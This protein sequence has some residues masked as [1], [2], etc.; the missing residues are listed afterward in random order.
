M[1]YTHLTV[2]IL[3]RVPAVDAKSDQ[4]IHVRGRY[5]HAVNEL[6]NGHRLDPPGFQRLVW[7][8]QTGIIFT[9]SPKLHAFPRV[10]DGVD[11][12]PADAIPIADGCVGLGAVTDAV[13]WSEYVN[14]RAVQNSLQIV[15]PIKLSHV[16]HL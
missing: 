12:V 1:V 6:L 8:A 14:L 5:V 9:I 3:Y 2:V 7:V 4:I 15:L 10:V 16:I 11:S 13:L